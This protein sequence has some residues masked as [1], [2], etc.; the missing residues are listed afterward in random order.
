MTAVSRIPSSYNVTIQVYNSDTGAGYEGIGIS[1]GPDDYGY[2]D[3]N[4]RYTFTDV[5]A[6]EY[7]IYI[8]YDSYHEGYSHYVDVGGTSR[9][10]TFEY[11]IPTLVTE[12]QGTISFTQYSSGNSYVPIGAIGYVDESPYYDEAVVTRV[13]VSRTSY[14]SK[15]YE[16]DGGSNIISISQSI[17][18]HK[19][20]WGDSTTLSSVNIVYDLE[21]CYINTSNLQGDGYIYI[22]GLFATASNP[23]YTLDY[24][25]SWEE[26]K[27]TIT[28]DQGH[29]SNCSCENV[30]VH[31]NTRSGNTLICY[32][33]NITCEQRTSY[34][35]YA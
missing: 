31:P 7:D 20:I 23:Q 22:E 16:K 10:I 2:T 27:L 34:E 15:I 9:D 18:V 24:P 21:S 26:A 12:L 14:V 1:F 35:D 3:S 11:S 33:H 4:G 29:I 25:I 8:F 6:G 19:E 32:I 30:Y 28:I 13:D 17:P 5:K